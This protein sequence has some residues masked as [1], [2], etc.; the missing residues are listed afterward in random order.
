MK[1]LARF[2]LIFLCVF[3]LGMAVAVLLAYRF[4]QQDAKDRI[5][6]QARLM[7]ETTLATRS[8]TTEQIKPLF[9]KDQR[10][11]FEFLPQTV[12]AFARTQV[13][14]YLQ[15]RNPEYAY[16][17]A[18]LNPSNP[19][20]RAGDWE[21]DII[22]AFSNDPNKKYLYGERDSAPEDRFTLP[23]R[24]KSMSRPVSNA[25]ALPIVRRSP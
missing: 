16:K 9:A 22:N 23:V 13:F 21:A 10:R 14:A 19:V 17:E 8:Y 6:E 20:D 3:G 2:N 25:T 12:P 4:L 5:R 15:K 18:T 11:Q 1:L 7:M 24:F